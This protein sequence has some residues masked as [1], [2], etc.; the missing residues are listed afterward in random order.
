[1]AA[2]AADLDFSAT[3]SFVNF[4]TFLPNGQDYSVFIAA[5]N[6][7]K[8]F[9]TFLTAAERTMHI[10]HM[11]RAGGWVVDGVL[12]TEKPSPLTISSLLN[13]HTNTKTHKKKKTV[14]RLWNLPFDF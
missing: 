3:F 8:A 6:Q 9:T 12:K 11:H 14:R 4:S 1:M 7:E 2:L 13:C 5:W 10:K